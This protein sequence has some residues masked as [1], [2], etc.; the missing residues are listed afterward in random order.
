V[1]FFITFVVLSLSKLLLAQ[2]RKGEGARHEHE[3][4]TIDFGPA[5]ALHRYNAASGSTRWP[6]LS[7][8]AMA[9]GLFWL[10]W[11]PV[12]DRARL[13]LGGLCWNALHQMTPPPNDTGGLANAIFGS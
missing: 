12:G 3:A 6:D 10:V 5:N 7:L 11:I 1:L 4:V 9:F 2:L 13:G 8:A